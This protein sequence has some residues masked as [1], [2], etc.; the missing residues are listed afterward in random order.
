MNEVQLDAEELSKSLWILQRNLDEL[1]ARTD[2][3]SKIGAPIS[4]NVLHRNATGYLKYVK[5]FCNEENEEH[6]LT[7][8]NIEIRLK[9]SRR[10]VRIKNVM[11]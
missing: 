6:K 9:S 2:E 3:L 10:K 7:L 8:L 11:N 5:K 1:K 4:I